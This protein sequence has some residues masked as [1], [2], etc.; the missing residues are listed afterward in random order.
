VAKDT[1]LKV[2]EA[3][4]KDGSKEKAARIVRD[5]IKELQS[6]KVPLE[7]L[8]ISTQIKKSPKSYEIKSPEISAAR[9]MLRAGIPVEKGSV[10]SYVIG[11]S[12][13]SISE[14]AEPLEL[15]KD[16]DTDYYIDNQLLPAVMKIMKE[17][18][19]DEYSMRHGGKQE[20]LDSFF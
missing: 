7:R 16:Y 19:Y 6:G 3:I 2:L 20:S 11:K 9:K 1:Q 17:L 10:I 8:A 14:K 12:G 15:A 13:K 5:M 18:G 4:L